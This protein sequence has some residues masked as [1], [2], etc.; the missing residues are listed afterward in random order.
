MHALLIDHE[1]F[2]LA[3]QQKD[4]TNV[5]QRYGRAGAPTGPLI[6]LDRTRCSQMR[7]APIE[8]VSRCC[9]PA[10]RVTLARWCNSGCMRA[11]VARFTSCVRRI[12][13]TIV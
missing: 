10:G 5:A 9:V 3:W 2:L 8:G 7:F 13:A 1:E 6:V 11:M 12:S 4:G